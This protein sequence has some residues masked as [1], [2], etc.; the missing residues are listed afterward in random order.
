MAR[1][2]WLGVI[3]VTQLGGVLALEVEAQTV[4]YVNG[5]LGTNGNGE[6]WGTAFNNLQSALSEATPDQTTPDQIWVAQETYKPS[7][8]TDPND[9]R[10]VCFDM[11]SGVRVYGGF[12]GGEGQLGDRRPDLHPTVLSGDIGTAG[13]SSDNAYCVVL[14]DGSVV[15]PWL[16]GFTITG[17]YGGYS[18]SCGAGIFITNEASPTLANLRIVDNEVTGKGAGIDVDSGSPRLTACRFENNRAGNGA[19]LYIASGAVFVRLDGCTFASNTALQQASALRDDHSGL[20][21]VVNTIFTGNICEGTD[22]GGTVAQFAYPTGLYINCLFDQ[23]ASLGDGAAIWSNS[24]GGLS[25]VNCT[26]TRNACLCGVGGGLYAQESTTVSNCIFWNNADHDDPDGTTEAAQIHWDWS[27][28]TVTHSCVSGLDQLADPPANTNIDD[29]PTFVGLTT[30]NLRLLPGSLCLNAGDN[31]AI[32]GITLDLD[33]HDRVVNTTVDMGPY[34][35]Q[36]TESDDCND[37]GILDECDLNCGPTGGA[38]DIPNCGLGAD[39]NLNGVLDKCEISAEPS[40]DCNSNGIPDECE[41]GSM[42][43]G[44]MEQESLT[45][46]LFPGDTAYAEAWT[47]Y[48]EWA[49]RQDWGPDSELTGAEQFELMVAKLQELGLPMRP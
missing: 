46:G 39:C 14:F 30:G 33:D 49:R 26:L 23:N 15:S 41:G 8:P 5:A 13:L 6:T 7:V 34:E 40:L 20:T 42:R 36:S 24:S 18:N 37:N 16:D 2:F 25:L 43:A 3:I 35:L 22:R 4:W 19:G 48:W 1:R 11:P 12:A 29:D 45:V 44:M 28:P 17:G 9:P 10:S 38:C 47:E 32:A 31:T 21:Q 27:M